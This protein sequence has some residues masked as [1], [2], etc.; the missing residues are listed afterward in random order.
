MLSFLSRGRLRD[1]A[2]RRGSPEVASCCS[3][4]GQPHT[5]NTQSLNDLEV[6]T[7]P[8]D[9]L[10]AAL[11][12]RKPVLPAAHL[13]PGPCLFC[14]HKHG[15]LI[16]WSQPTLQKVASCWPR[17]C[18]PAHGLGKTTYFSAFQ[19]SELYLLQGGLSL[20]LGER[21]PFQA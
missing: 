8:G 16:A 1:T 19:W 13:C 15:L 9:D 7:W 20:S 14:L 11:P 3:T 2:G 21:A 4:V 6:S 12:T 18:R 17:K 10:P 5:K